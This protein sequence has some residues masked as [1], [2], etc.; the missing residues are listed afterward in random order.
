M[1]KQLNVSLNFTA[2]TQQAKAQMQELQ[3]QLNAL[4]TTANIPVGQRIKDD[5]L[6][7][8][9]AAAELKTTLD[10]AVN[11]NTGKLDLTKFST[12]L[13]SSGKDLKYYRENE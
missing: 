2:N 3:R 1:A 10:G 4:G 5:I 8:T 6:G 11:A 7:A 13:K 9:K 12:G